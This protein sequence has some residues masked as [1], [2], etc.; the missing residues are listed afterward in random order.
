MVLFYV[1]VIVVLFVFFFLFVLEKVCHCKRSY[2]QPMTSVPLWD[3]VS[4]LFSADQEVVL[5]APSAA[6]YMAA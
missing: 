2:A 6:P 5:S 4:S 1:F 3:T